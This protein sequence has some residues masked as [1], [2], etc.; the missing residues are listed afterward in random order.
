MAISEKN[1]PDVFLHGESTGTGFLVPL[2][3]NVC[4]FL[5]LPF[6][7][8]L[9]VFLKCEEEMLCVFFAHIFDAKIIDG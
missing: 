8:E 7:S 6:V 4:V 9:V 2:E 1:F 3:I 5:P